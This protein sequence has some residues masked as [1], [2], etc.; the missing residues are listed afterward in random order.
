[1]AV[2][3]ASTDRTQHPTTPGAY[4]GQGGVLGRMTCVAMT[5]LAQE[6]WPCLEHGGDGGAMGLMTDGTVLGHRL[7]VVHERATLFRVA[8]K[9]SLVD[10]VFL[11][12]FGTGRAMGIVAVGTT[13]LTF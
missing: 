12:L 2:Q 4:I 8:L 1:M 6:G 5:F 3:A 13:H 10:A 9:T 11:E 7:M